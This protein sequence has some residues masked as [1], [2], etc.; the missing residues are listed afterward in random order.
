MR[1]NK[2]WSKKTLEAKGLWEDRAYDGNIILEKIFHL[3]RKRSKET[4]IDRR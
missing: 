2:K 4:A 1:N 3:S